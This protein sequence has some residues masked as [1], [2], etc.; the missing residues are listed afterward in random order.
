MTFLEYVLADSSITSEIQQGNAF[1]FRISI[2]ELLIVL[3]YTFKLS[4]FFLGCSFPLSSL[5]AYTVYG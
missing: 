3:D 5:A 4:Q 1:V 2:N